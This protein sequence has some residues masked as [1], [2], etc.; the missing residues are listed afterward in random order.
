MQINQ[1]YD[2]LEQGS[3]FSTVARKAARVFRPPIR[4]RTSSRLASRRRNPSPSCRRSSTRCTRRSRI[5]LEQETFHGYGDEQG[6][7]FLHEALAG[8]Y[9]THGVDARHR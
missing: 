6:Y 3:L 4:R 8:Y 2:N 5:R 9:R 7:G 1:N